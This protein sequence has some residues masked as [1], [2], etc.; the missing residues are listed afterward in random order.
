MILSF[1]NIRK[2]LGFQ[3]FPRDL[4]NVNE[5]KIIF[6]P[7]NNIVRCFYQWLVIYIFCKGLQGKSANKIFISQTCLCNMQQLLKVVKMMISG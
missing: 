1:I 6:D 4:V 3:H 2:T 7:S 5:C